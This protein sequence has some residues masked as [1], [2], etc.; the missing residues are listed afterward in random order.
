MGEYKKCSEKGYCKW[1]LERSDN[2]YPKKKGLLVSTL[3]DMVTGKI[4]GQLLVYST[5]KNKDKGMA[6]NFCPFCG[7]SFYDLHKAGK[8]VG[9]TDGQE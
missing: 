7:F 4:T 8:R 9:G 1:L 3:M 5:G 6:V 2:F